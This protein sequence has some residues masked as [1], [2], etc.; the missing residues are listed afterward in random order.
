[1]DGRWVE[2]GAG[3]GGA[4]AQRHRKR[5]HARPAHLFRECHFCR[6]PSHSTSPS[7]ETDSDKVVATIGGVPGCDQCVVGERAFGRGSVIK[8]ERMSAKKQQQNSQS[9]REDADHEMPWPAT[10]PGM[11]PGGR[12]GVILPALTARIN[13]PSVD[14]PLPK[15]RERS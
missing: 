13:T 11:Q 4:T 6:E 14:W 7:R 5:I 15:S 2:A 12:E 10:L 8:F 3:V 9:L 1:M